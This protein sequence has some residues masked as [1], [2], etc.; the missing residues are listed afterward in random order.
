MPTTHVVF[1]GPERDFLMGSIALLREV[2]FSRIVLVTGNDPKFSGEALVQKTAKSL[3]RDLGIFWPV[4]VVEVNKSSVME[5]ANQI[6]SIINS[7]RTLG[8]DVLLNV[9][10]ALQPLSMSAYIA[11]SMSR[12]RVVSALPNYSDD[13]TLVGALEIV[14]IP[15]LPIGYPGAEQQLLISRI[16]DG[17]ESLDSLIYLMF[18]EI[19][20]NSKRFRSERSRLSHHLSKLESG[21]FI[22][23]T[24]YGRNIAIRLTCLGQMFA[25]VISRGDVPQ[26]D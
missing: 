3:S 26:D 9:A 6:L 17:V 13:G 19:D 20:K 15:V 8:N 22:V 11:A 7:E 12:A 16:G 24:K 1:V 21:G 2:G 10:S 18:P 23:K 14:E 5:A 4:S 25:Q